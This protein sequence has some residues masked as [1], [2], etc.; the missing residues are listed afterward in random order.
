[1]ASSTSFILYIL[2]AGEKSSKK[3]MSC[4]KLVLT[5]SS[6]DDITSPAISKLGSFCNFVRRKIW[7]S[8]RVYDSFEWAY[9]DTY[10][11]CYQNLYQNLHKFLSF[12]FKN[13]L[14]CSE[15]VVSLQRL[16]LMVFSHE[17]IAST[18]LPKL[19]FICVI[20]P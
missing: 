8:D 19:S 12:S 11:M 5:T 16:V 17:H 20:I 15:R 9:N 6:H 13:K 14:E 3:L 2:R 1:M 7:L 10:Y 18:G 4:H